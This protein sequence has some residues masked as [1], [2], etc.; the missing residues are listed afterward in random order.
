MITF[1]IWQADSC[2]GDTRSGGGGGGT[3]AAG[4]CG[5]SSCGSRGGGGSAAGGAAS[6]RTTCSSRSGFGGTNDPRLPSAHIGACPDLGWSGAVVRDRTQPREHTTSAP[7]T[8]GSVTPTR[9]H[10]KLATTWEEGRL[11]APPVMEQAGPIHTL[12]PHRL[13]APSAR[14]SVHTSA[15]TFCSSPLLTP[16]VHTTFHIWQVGGEAEDE[17]ILSV[18]ILGHVWVPDAEG[19][20]KGASSARAPPFKS[21][22]ST[23]PTPFPAPRAQ[24][25][26]AGMP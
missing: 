2:F 6:V 22:A 18:T 3:A 15:R 20:G 9:A 16:S 23:T 14:T 24:H 25:R 7:C 17:P 1:L 8:P 19:K 13:F 5:G 4:S 11:T 21:P 12:C 10:S 26:V